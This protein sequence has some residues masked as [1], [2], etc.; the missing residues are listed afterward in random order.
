MNFISIEFLYFFGILSDL[1]E[2]SGKEQKVSLDRRIRVFLFRIQ[3]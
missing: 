1:L 3:S 2:R